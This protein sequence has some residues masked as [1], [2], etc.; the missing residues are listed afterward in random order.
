MILTSARSG[1]NFLHYALK[2]H[3][4]IQMFGEVFNLQA[5]SAPV[6]RRLLLDPVK[7]ADKLLNK[8][9][10]KGKMVLGFKIFYNQMTPE[11]VD[12]EFYS[13]YFIQRKDVSNEEAAQIERLKRYIANTFD[14]VA[15]KARIEDVWSYFQKDTRIKILHLRRKNH[16]KQYLSICRAWQSNEWIS[17]KSSALAQSSLKPIR[18]EYHNCLRFFEKLGEWEKKFCRHF[19]R[20]QVHDVFYEDL[21]GDPGVE[22]EKVQAFLGLPLKRL[23][24]QLRKQRQQPVSEAIVNYGELKA[25]FKGSCYEDYFRNQR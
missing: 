20:H 13:T 21:T 6:M 2:S 3:E 14:V 25:R 15:A 7:Y 22:L 19:S 9:C 17:M 23:D 10:P 24:V 16:L 12:C 11:Q 1:S 18:I 5:A 8:K 4:N